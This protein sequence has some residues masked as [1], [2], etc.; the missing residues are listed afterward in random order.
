[1]LWELKGNMTATRTFSL[2]EMLGEG[3]VISMTPS[4]VIGRLGPKG[5]HGEYAGYLHRNFRAPQ[6]AA[7]ACFAACWCQ[8][9]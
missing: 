5:G 3:V 6:R 9:G 1:M 7:Y 8:R 4:L 2:K